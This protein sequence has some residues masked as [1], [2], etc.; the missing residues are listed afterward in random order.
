MFVF[1]N[2]MFAGTVIVRDQ[3][4]SQNYEPSNGTDGWALLA[5]GDAFLNDVT[6]RGMFSTGP[7][8]SPHIIIADSAAP[9]FNGVPRILLY[10]GD[11]Q[12]ILPAAVANFQNAGVS[13]F[14]I[15]TSDDGF[16]INQIVGIPPQ[17]AVSSGGWLFATTASGSDIGHVE[18]DTDMQLRILNQN[19]TSLSSTNHGFQVGPT[20]SFNIAVSDAQIQKR[21]NGAASALLLNEDGGNVQV[22]TVAGTGTLVALNS[23]ALALATTNNGF[24]IG[25]DAALNLV[26]DYQG[27]QARSNG[28]A[29]T[30]VLQN[31]GGST[32]FGGPVVA[33]AMQTVDQVDASVRTT[34]STAYAAAG[35]SATYTTVSP[36]SGF[37]L[38]LFSCIASAS[39]GP[40]ER[41]LMSFEIRQNNATGTALYAAGD[42][43]AVV[44]NVTVACGAAGYA[45]VSGLPTNGSTIFIRPMFRSTN[46][47]STATFNRI[48][49]TTIPMP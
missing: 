28:V 12:E 20:N 42:N 16:G 10:S 5:N 9:P 41:A 27:I 25:T 13:W 35:S 26:A 36:S 46:A 31:W 32:V 33:P 8:G 29:T 37:A 1:D 43:G 49:I 6:I 40:A 39:G 2:V 11:P 3:M 24:M 15:D 17:S 22:G 45:Y 14:E 21:N 44:Q 4:E 18:L 19:N 38:V 7:A 48:T 30:L 34:T 47:A 23:N